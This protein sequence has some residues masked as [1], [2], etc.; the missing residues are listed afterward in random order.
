[1][2]YSYTFQQLDHHATHLA[3]ELRNHFQ[4]PNE[5]WLIAVCLHPSIELII[6]LL[7]IFKSGAAYLPLDPSFPKDRVALLLKDANPSLILTSTEILNEKHFDQISESENKIFCIDSFSCFGTCTDQLAI[8]LSQQ[9]TMIQQDLAVVLFTSGSTGVPK[10]ARLTQSTILNR[11]NWQWCT[12]PYATGEV[13]IFKTSLTF[14]DSIIEIWAPLLKGVPL[15]IVPK[16]L[17]QNPQLF[18]NTLERFNI[19]RLL[20]VPSLSSSILS[21]ITK[22]EKVKLRSLRHWFCTGEIL[23]VYLLNAFYQHLDG[24]VCNMYGSTEITDVTC[25]LFRS[26]EDVNSS[27]FGGQVPLG[28]IMDFSKTIFTI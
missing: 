5:D 26:K 25:Q 11:L 16:I 21:S 13:A 18:V 23:S 28:I 2:K 9:H 12:F 27:I 1:M 17:T 8:G 3:Q 7:A 4:R 22:A 14:V 6:G 20:L 15:V 10:G 19:T 24:V